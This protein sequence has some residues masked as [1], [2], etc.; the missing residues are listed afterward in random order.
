LDHLEAQR[1]NSVRSR[2]ARLTAIRSFYRFASY[3]EPAHAALI[4]QV[5][6]IPEKRANRRIVSY[7]A[8]DEIDALLTAPDR[9]TW[10]GRRDHALLALT[11]QAGLR[12]SEL[13]RLKTADVVL[14]AGPHIRVEGKGRKERVTPLNRHS[15][16]V[17][18]A[19]L[20]EQGSDPDQAL[21][22]ARTGR[23]LST[24]AVSDLL[25][26]HVARAAQNCPSLKAKRVSPHTLRH[27]CAMTL[28]RQGVDIT[29]IALWLGHEHVQTTQIYTHGDLSIKE[30]ALARTTPAG[31]PV[32]RYRPP[33]QL[34]AFLESL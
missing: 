25:D 16:R 4:S 21:F 28:L 7:L 23:P 27:T 15:V 19:W 12:V 34:L 5:L 6:A 20:H 22:P 32:G 31:T 13:T 26:K 24:D 9:S 29:V 10:L 33:D 3:R 8:P 11:V 30:R 2:N 1:H 18:S 14:G 17:L